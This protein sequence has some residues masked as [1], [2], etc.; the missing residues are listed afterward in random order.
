[1]I[2]AERRRFHRRH[3]ASILNKCG[4]RKSDLKNV[5]IHAKVVNG[6]QGKENGSNGAPHLFDALLFTGKNVMKMVKR[7]STFYRNM[8]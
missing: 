1:M 5:G 8:I 3:I 7:R 4:I 2:L 6:R